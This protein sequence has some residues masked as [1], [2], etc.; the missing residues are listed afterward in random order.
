MEDSKAFNTTLVAKNWRRLYRNPELL[1]SRVYKVVHYPKCSLWEAKKGSSPSY[2]W[3]SLFQSRWLLDDEVRWQVWSGVAIDITDERWLPLGCPLIYR[4]DLANDLGVKT[5]PI[6]QVQQD[7]LLYWPHVSNGEYDTKY[8]YVV[9]R[10]RADRSSPS[11]SSTH[12]LP[13]SFWKQLWKAPAIQRCIELVWRG[14]L[15]ILPV[16]EVLRARGMDVDVLCPWCKVQPKSIS[17]VL[18]HY[19]VVQRWWFASDLGLRL[20][21][22]DEF[23][24]FS[25]KLVGS[26]D[27]QVVAAFCTFCY[28]IWEARNDL[29]FNG[30]ETRVERLLQRAHALRPPKDEQRSGGNIRPLARSWQ[31]PTQGITK[32]NF[33]ATWLLM[34]DRVLAVWL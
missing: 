27:P 25:Q 17:H 12:E 21:E 11:S 2:T 8:G 30:V 28:V 29:L 1:L 10:A 22:E 7:D 31:R 4:E 34:V 23:H 32:F 14:C 24:E 9:A 33:D 19:L 20:T 6:P 3:S 18:L 26:H 5:L 13:S 15:K 16:R